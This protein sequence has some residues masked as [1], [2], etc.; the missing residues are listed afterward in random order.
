MADARALAVTV[1]RRFTVDD[2]D[3][4]VV[5]DHVLDAELRGHVGLSR[6]IQLVEFRENEE[7]SRRPVE[8]L[9]D[10]AGSALVDGGGHP[11]MVVAERATR[12]CIEKARV[13][14][15]AIVA[16]NN[17]RHSGLLSFYVEQV[18]LEGLVAIALAVGHPRVAP[19]G[20]RVARLGTNPLAFGFPTSS[21]PI[22]VDLATSAISG[23]ELRRRARDQVPLPAG[24][25]LDS[26]GRPTLNAAE[27]LDG[28]LVSW[29]GHRGFGLAVAIQLLGVMCGMSA[30]PSGHEG[31]SFLIMA[32][33]PALFGTEGTYEERAEE[34]ANVIRATPTAES[35]DEVRMPFDRSRA[36]RRRRVLEGVTLSSATYARLHAIA[37]AA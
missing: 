35:F 21:D 28:A 36:E 12:L 22:I 24:I 18:A 34:L 4:A 7:Q 1:A 37:N 30:Q 9:H 31:W 10:R 14:G 32:I 3:A 17:H 8:V 25:A 26:A 13:Q 15:W 29:G 27:A 2:H 11:G 23:G 6:L 20:G 16:A 5:A 19:Y 33:S